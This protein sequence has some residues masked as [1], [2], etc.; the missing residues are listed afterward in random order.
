VAQVPLAEDEH[1]VRELRPGGNRSDQSS[2]GF[3]F[4][5][6]STWFS[7]QHQQFG[8]QAGAASGEQGQPGQDP[9]E[10]KVAKPYRHR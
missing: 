1:P 7:W 3:G 4:A 9:A 2:H 10:Y 8:V 5:R 6:R